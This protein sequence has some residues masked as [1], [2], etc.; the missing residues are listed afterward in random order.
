MVACPTDPLLAG[1]ASSG[2]IGWRNGPGCDRRVS[3][4]TDQTKHA[5]PDRGGTSHSRLVRERIKRTVLKKV[6]TRDINLRLPHE[7]ISISCLTRKCVTI[8]K[9][10]AL[11]ISHFL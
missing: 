10:T 4:G 2:S 5:D 6:E 8:R 9:I 3:G 7:M 11:S 1:T